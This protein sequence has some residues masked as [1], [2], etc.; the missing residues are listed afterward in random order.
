MEV[1]DNCNNP[2]KYTNLSFLLTDLTQK[3]MTTSQATDTYIDTFSSTTI[4]TCPSDSC[5]FKDCSIL[6][7]TGEICP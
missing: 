6:D 1:I 5:D 4:F 3:Q 7:S 2:N